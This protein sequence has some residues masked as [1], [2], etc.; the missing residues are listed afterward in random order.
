MIR[1]GAVNANGT[2]RERGRPPSIDMF[3]LMIAAF[4]DV[5][6]CSLLGFANY[7][8]GNSQPVSVGNISGSPCLNDRSVIRSFDSA[9]ACNQHKYRALEEGDKALV[10]ARR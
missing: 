1:A 9:F 2:G 6:C 4:K 3:R 8:L 5:I 7:C 10:F